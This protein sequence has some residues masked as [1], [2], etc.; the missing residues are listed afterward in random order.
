M[1]RIRSVVNNIYCSTSKFSHDED[2]QNVTKN[3]LN[4]YEASNNI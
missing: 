4:I 3:V 1:N 2:S